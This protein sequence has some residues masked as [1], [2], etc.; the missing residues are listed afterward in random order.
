MLAVGDGEGRG[1]SWLGL[2]RVNA[3]SAETL[4]DS[5][6]LARD[7]VEAAWSGE[8]AV[9]VRLPDYL[10]AAL[11][12]GDSGEGVAWLRRRAATLDPD[13]EAGEDAYSED[14]ESWVAGFQERVGL[15]VTGTADAAT[16]VLAAAHG[17]TDES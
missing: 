11:A 13:M 8:Y 12:P 5:G 16:L 1:R 6:R 17:G 7:A 15:P 10:P 3:D 14:L 9:L 4:G 2:R